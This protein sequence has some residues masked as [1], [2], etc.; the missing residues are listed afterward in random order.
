MID[1][2]WFKHF[3]SEN[4]KFYK[5]NKQTDIQTI[6]AALVFVEKRKGKKRS[7]RELEWCGVIIRWYG[8]E[9]QKSPGQKHYCWHY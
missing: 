1:F 2:I 5:I 7:L 6:L 9:E 8:I 4:N 3:K